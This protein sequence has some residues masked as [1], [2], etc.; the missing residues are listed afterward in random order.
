MSTNASP[1]NAGRPVRPS[2][3]WIRFVPVRTMFRPVEI[4]D[5]QEI[6]RVWGLPVATFVWAIV[7]DQ[8]ARWR[9]GARDLGQ[10]GLAIAAGLAVTR[11]ATERRFRPAGNGG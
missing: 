2:P 11:N 4:G 1:D 6:S 7:V 10:H 5:L 8:I 9:K 3:P